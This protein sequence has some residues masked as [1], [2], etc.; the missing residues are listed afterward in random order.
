MIPSSSLDYVYMKLIGQN[1]LLAMAQANL[2]A[3]MDR[4]RKVRTHTFLANNGQTETG[5]SRNE[6]AE[7]YY[8]WEDTIIDCRNSP[9]L[10][11]SDQLMD[12]PETLE[13]NKRFKLF[14]DAIEDR[15]GGK[16]HAVAFYKVMRGEENKRYNI[17]IKSDTKSKIEDFDTIRIGL[18]V[19]ADS[20]NDFKLG[21]ENMR[22]WEKPFKVIGLD[23]VN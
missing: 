16:L 2:L 23:I 14:Q 12:F 9:A 4:I 11:A 19:V 3:N 22:N 7:R 18:K 8:V 17:K 6:G 5:I 1:T 13:S 21:L 10:P 15:S 20:D